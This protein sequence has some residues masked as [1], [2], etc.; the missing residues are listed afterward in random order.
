MKCVNTQLFDPIKNKCVK[1]TSKRGLELKRL[2]KVCR[3]YEKSDPNCKV[4][5][6]TYKTTIFKIKKILQKMIVPIISIFIFNL[7]VFL[8][9]SSKKV[10]SK[11]LSFSLKHHPST[12]PYAYILEPMIN[13]IPGVINFIEKYGGIAKLAVFGLDYNNI[14]SVIQSIINFDFSNTTENIVL[15]DELA[16]RLSEL[17]GSWK[18]TPPQNIIPEPEILQRVNNLEDNIENFIDNNDRLTDNDYINWISNF[19]PNS[20][21]NLIDLITTLE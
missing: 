1:V 11:I 9:L 6:K 2:I 20:F 17:P 10:R 14:I 8:T 19:A 16:S 12:A 4:I 5:N 18:D 13:Y 21:N 15:E 3:E 7:L